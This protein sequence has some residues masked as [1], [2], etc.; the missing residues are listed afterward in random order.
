MEDIY[1]KY[2][3]LLV[4]YCLELK[5]GDRCYVESS[6]LAEPLIK[7]FYRE[8]M[9]VGAHVDFKLSFP[10]MNKI[11]FEEA[12]DMQLQFVSP[13]KMEAFSNYEAYMLIR[14]PYD[15]HEEI[16]VDKGKKQ[17]RS[18]ALHEL[19]QL[20][21]K[22]TAEKSMRRS[23]CQFPT[24]TVAENAGMTLEEYSDFVFNACKLYADDPAAEWRRLGET[25]QKIVDFLD[26]SKHIRYV[27]PRS[28]ISFSVEGRKW[29]NSDG[30]AN[31]P[32]G[33]VFS[34]PVEESVNGEIYFDYP[35]IFWG[36]DV[37]GIRLKV[38]NGQII[39]WSAE[40]GGEVLDKI[41]QIDGA[42]YF[43][44]VAVGTNY[45]VHRSTKNILFDE[46]IGGTIHM[47]IGQSYLQA[48]GKNQSSI[49]WD[50]IANMMDGAIY[51]D[52]ALIYQ[53]GKFVDMLK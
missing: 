36:Q 39:E 53:N 10:E 43:G 32:S 51:A 18:K 24:D 50:M 41:M 42:R 15:L 35:S 2:A 31:M 6:M 40:Q 12:S 38:Q 30:K 23:L 16:R 47:A 22:R 26:K 14:A 13:L 29:I 20:Y 4:N 34:A 9:R 11:F 5:E 21:F 17:T 45:D 25:Q 19:N 48:G 7:E 44:E 46:K 49:H 3:N 37:S 33:E 28:D 8:A 1:R 52:G 27:N